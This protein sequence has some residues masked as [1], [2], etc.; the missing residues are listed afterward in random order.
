MYIAITLNLEHARQMV[1]HAVTVDKA[2]SFCPSATH[3]LREHGYHVTPAIT[4]YRA[5]SHARTVVLVNREL[6][7]IVKQ[8]AA[9]YGLQEAESVGLR[10]YLY[11][12]LSSIYYMYFVVR[13]YKTAHRFY[14]VDGNKVASGGYNAM[15]RG[16]A[17]QPSAK[18]L[19]YA[20]T[21]YSYPHYLVTSLF[22]SILMFFITRSSRLKVID[23]GDELPK[24]IIGAMIN[25]GETPIVVNARKVSKNIYKSTRL[26]LKSLI[27]LRSV[28]S[29][30]KPVIVF[31]TTNPCRY[32]D[33]AE[34][35][36][37]TGLSSDEVAD[38]VKSAVKYFIPFL[39]AEYALGNKLVTTLRPDIAVSDHAKYAFILGGLEAL[40]A[41]HGLHAMLNHGTHTIQYGRLSKMAAVL[42]GRQERIVNRN[43]THALPKSPLTAQLAKEIRHDGYAIEKINVYGVIRRAALQENSDKLILLHAGNYTDAYSTIP[44]CKETADEYLMGIIELLEEIQRQDNVQLIIKL[45]AKK[46]DTHK[47]ILEAY[48]ARLNLGDKAVI[49]TTS[50]FSEIM[51]K[52]HLVVSNLSGTVEEA[53]ANHIPVMIHTYWKTYSHIPQEIVKQS[54]R[55]QLAPAYLVKN[56]Q[57]IGTIISRLQSL[58]KDLNSKELYR[59]VAWQENELTNLPDFARHLVTRARERRG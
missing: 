39:R 34:D 55:G 20:Y 50:K 11:H 17:S 18:I 36:T 56:K 22:N 4:H 31:R 19:S 38:A 3:Y 51:S 43:T 28:P 49:D 25:N 29:V 58:K 30:G 26:F 1:K 27:R 32:R 12:Y 47:A 53:L 14:W 37:L 6:P 2:V 57:D 9:Q 41:Y 33:I 46:A 52:T 21:R 35:F 7:A 59:N 48:I 13:W 8:A 42:W 24:R 40:G 23:F 45:K 5:L 16:I 15:Y 10:V 54:S 44:W